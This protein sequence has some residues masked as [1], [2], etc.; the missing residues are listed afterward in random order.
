[1][2]VWSWPRVYVA[3]GYG[4]RHGLT[5]KAL[6]KNVDDCIV[7]FVR[8]LIERGFNPYVPLLHHYVHLNWD[9]SPDEETYFGLVASWIGDCDLFLVGTRPKWEGSG[10]ERE[11]G[12][13]KDLEIPVF[14]SLE[15]IDAVYR[16][17]GKS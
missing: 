5:D 11:I 1:M 15:V 9:E 17:A 8:P 13:A 3:H 14:Y 10:V 7:N 6:Q 12:I 2:N 4:R 16:T